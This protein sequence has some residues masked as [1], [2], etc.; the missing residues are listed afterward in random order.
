[1]QELWDRLESRL[2]DIEPDVLRDLLP[3]VTDYEI[4]SAEEL[5]GVR[6][7]EDAEESY[8]IHDGQGGDGPP[9]IMGEWQL[10]SLEDMT[11]Q[12]KLMKDLSDTGVFMEAQGSPEGPVRPDWWNTK[13]IPVAYNGAG[14]LQ[15][16][17]MDPAAGGDSGQLITFWHMN[18]NREVIADS[19]RTWLQGC[20]DSLANGR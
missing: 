11:H 18:P 4:R 19:F 1:V 13:W 7:P 6:L 8:K 9:L 12:W 20:I 15:C 5:M 17:D 14:D 3:G 10:L 2:A 16:L